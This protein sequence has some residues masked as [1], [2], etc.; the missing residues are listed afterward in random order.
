MTTKIRQATPTD[1]P[2][3]TTL[4]REG[5]EHDYVGV[6]P[7]GYGAASIAR[8]GTREA[9]SQQLATYRYYFVAEDAAGQVVGVICGDHVSDQAAEIWWIHTTRTARGKGVGRQ[10]LDHFIAALPPAI[11]TL[12]VT[13]FQ[14]YFPTIT[15]YERMGFVVARTEVATYDGF[16][17]NDLIL[18]RDLRQ[19]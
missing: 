4:Q 1:I 17:V 14:G 15:F 11:T 10:L 13:T 16:I 3:L 5:W 18:Q 6:M 2:T 19:T 7:V 8:Y 9:L 12:S